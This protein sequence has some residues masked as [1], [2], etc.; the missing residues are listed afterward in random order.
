[1]WTV[2]KLNDQNFSKLRRQW[3]SFL[4]EENVCKSIE[5]EDALHLHASQEEADS[6]SR[7]AARN[8]TE[9]LLKLGDRGKA[10]PQ[11][12]YKESHLQ[13]WL[14]PDMKWE[15]EK[16]REWR[17]LPTAK[18]RRWQLMVEQRWQYLRRVRFVEEKNEGMCKPCSLSKG[19]ESPVG[20]SL[21]R[22]KISWGKVL[23]ELN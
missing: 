5:D 19:S 6:F 23:W 3:R 21:Y 2:L 20:G 22:G 9:N 11:L 18:R 1:M 17:M 16:N 13:V 10:A 14:I 4:A 12:C 15:R 8:P 7:Q